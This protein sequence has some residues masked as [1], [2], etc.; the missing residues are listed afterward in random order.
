MYKIEFQIKIIK[1]HVTIYIILSSNSTGSRCCG[2]VVARNVV[3][4]TSPFRR[5]FDS[6]QRQIYF[7]LHFYFWFP[8]T[9]D[10]DVL[11]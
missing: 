5:R 3:V 10:Y 6:A 4:A 8:S 1:M 9:E 11:L 2:V 7:A